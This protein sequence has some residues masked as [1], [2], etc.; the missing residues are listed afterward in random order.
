MVKRTRSEK[1]TGVYSYPCASGRVKREGEWVKWG[2]TVGQ[3]RKEGFETERLAQD[4][5]IQVLADRRPLDGGRITLGDWWDRWLRLRDHEIA[6]NTLRNYKRHKTWFEPI[7]GRKLAQLTPFE[8]QEWQANALK[9]RA[10]Y[11]VKMSMCALRT[12]LNA[13][14]DAE[15]IERSPARRVKVV[16]GLP[17]PPRTWTDEQ[18]RQFIA[19]T[20]S[21]ERWGVIFRF[22]AETW[23][24]VGE[25]GGLRWGDLDLD[26]GTAFIQRTFHQENRIG[27]TK[28]RRTRVIQLSPGLTAD[29]RHHRDRVR[30]EREITADAHVFV[31]PRGNPLSGQSVRTRL[32]RESARLGLPYVNPHGLRHTG[33]GLEYQDRPDLIQVISERLGH[34]NTNITY[35]TYVRTN[36]E[37]HQDVADRVGGRF[38]T[39]PTPEREAMTHS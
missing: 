8:I 4:H 11:S 26:R 20:A 9:T 34:V 30:F 37:M 16:A 14:V 15:L 28:T 27:P 5:R 36:A 21:D 23:V 38:D 19:G 7:C 17:K 31:S 12:V 13:A 2:C 33:G 35:K 6:P 32:I 25:V 39:N 29:L 24:R 1:Y 10:P 18:V 22:M 3:Y